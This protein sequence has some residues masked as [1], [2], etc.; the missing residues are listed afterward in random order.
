MPLAR[1]PFNIYMTNSNVK[2]LLVEDDKTLLEM[3]TLKFKEAGFN[4]I[5][6]EEGETGLGLAKK[7]L[8]AVILLDIMMPKMDGFAVLTELR[9]DEKTKKIPILM[10]S[11]LGQES[12]VKKGKKLG[13][14]DYIVKASMTPTQVVDKTK[15]YLK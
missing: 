10:L 6:A 14:N 4:I 8:P 5:T 7:E 1:N 12:D 13:A 11:N 9:Q 2:I 3:Y 15:S